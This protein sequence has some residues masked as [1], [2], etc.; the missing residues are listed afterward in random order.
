MITVHTFMIRR[1]SLKIKYLNR[2]R[3][4]KSKPEQFSLCSDNAK[5]TSTKFAF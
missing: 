1:R 3:P 2:V 4:R 5:D